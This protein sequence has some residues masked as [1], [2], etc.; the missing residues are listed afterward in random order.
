ML[1]MMLIFLCVPFGI[2]I[3]MC[4]HAVAQNESAN[5]ESAIAAYVDLSDSFAKLHLRQK[6]KLLL[7]LGRKDGLPEELM[8]LKEQSESLKKIIAPLE[9]MVASES[10]KLTVAKKARNDGEITNKEYESIKTSARLTLD[11]SAE[12]YL[13]L[14]EK[15]LLP[16]QMKL[17]EKIAAQFAIRGLANRPHPIE[18]P[19]ALGKHLGMPSER[20]RILA[21][22]TFE[23]QESL[24]KELSDK[25]RDFRKVE[26]EFLQKFRSKLPEGLQTSFVGV[27]HASK[28]QNLEDRI[29]RLRSV[30]SRV[31]SA[32]VLDEKEIS[33]RAEQIPTAVSEYKF[34][35]FRT[36]QGE[37]PLF[38]FSEVDPEIK[39]LQDMQ[40]ADATDAF[41]QASE[42]LQAEAG[43]VYAKFDAG[44]IS[45]ETYDLFAKQYRTKVM[46]LRSAFVLACEESLLPEQTL[47]LESAATNK[48]IGI[49]MDAMIPNVKNP[50]VAYMFLGSALGL[51]KSEIRK[52]ARL[53]Q[54]FGEEREARTS[55]LRRFATEA[56]AKAASSVLNVLTADEKERFEELLGNQLL[57]LLDDIAFEELK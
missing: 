26:L 8:V 6:R 52:L 46:L 15:E 57:N 56:N 7:Q 9:E 23:T 32:T 11:A 20:F 50:F 38:A 31:S 40:I 36:S 55:E 45:K 54:D 25:E 49:S 18:F 35:A 41:E 27:E 10:G 33:R 22:K 28:F 42:L 4:E 44:N 30:S 1:R 48:A 2:G 12:E 51:D 16:H 17:F 13:G 53:V 37:F 14:I 47:E 3:A 39:H 19:C 43:E 21:I 5:I 29:L 34:E 24:F